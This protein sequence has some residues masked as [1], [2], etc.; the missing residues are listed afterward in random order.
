MIAQSDFP[1]SK[2]NFEI[3]F[4]SLFGLK[5][6]PLIVYIRPK[7]S[8]TMATELRYYN[9]AKFF[10]KGQRK[11]SA[12]IDYCESFKAPITPRANKKYPVSQ[13]ILNA[14]F[15]K[16]INEIGWD[17]QNKRVYP[18][19]HVIKA[20]HEGDFTGELE[21]CISVFGEIE[22]GNVGSSFRDLIKFIQVESFSTYD[23]IIFI[24][25]KK[26]FAKK[27]ESIGCYEDLCKIIAYL[28]TSLN[29][30]ILIIGIEP[31]TNQHYLDCEIHCALTGNQ[32]TDWQT[33][34]EQYWDDFVNKHA[35][36]LF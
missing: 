7:F 11:V 17:V 32:T 5:I 14:M 22:F 25:P 27:I 31:K 19:D 23:A 26:Q 24:L 10:F 3:H 35:K 30:P 18:N 1:R 2:L 12:L 4:D 16:K 15:R 8:M 29:V 13:K 33:Q 34:K 20:N 9:K 21:N 6:H 36:T 28:S